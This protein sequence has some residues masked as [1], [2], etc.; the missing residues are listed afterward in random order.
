MKNKHLFITIVAVLLA[1]SI[2]AQV[3]TID[4]V[5]VQGGVFFMGCT[6]RRSECSPNESPAH[7][8]QLDGFYIAKYEV[9]QALWMAVMGG[10]NPS[11]IVGDSL[12]VTGVSWYDTQ[13]FIGKL[14]QLT[15]KKYRLL[16]EAEWEYAARGG[17]LTNNY[18][19]SGSNDMEEVAWCKDNSD[20]IPHVVGTKQPNELG[21]YDMSGNVYEWCSDG[22]DMY[23]WNSSTTV[24]NPKGYNL[25]ETKVYRGGCMTSYSDD[26]RVFA[27]KQ[28]IPNTQFNFV[29]FR[30]ALDE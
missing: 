21:I 18:K 15:G 23:E 7:P 8:V 9:T 25:S 5:H 4:M 3:P 13:T 16:T 26:C 2:Y 22:F 14:N 11:K 1:S 28:A 20:N 10:K 17:L 24:V 29:G 27:R 19:Y 30:L 12:P 6:D